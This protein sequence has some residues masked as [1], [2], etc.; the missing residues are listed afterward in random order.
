MRVYITADQR[1]ERRAGGDVHGTLATNQSKSSQQQ[2]MSDSEAP[3]PAVTALKTSE[4]E[5][6]NA[7]C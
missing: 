4:T 5:L 2:L 7:T 1:P 3:E 6:A